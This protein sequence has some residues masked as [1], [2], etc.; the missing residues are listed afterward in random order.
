MRFYFNGTEYT[1]NNTEGGHSSAGTFTIGSNQNGGVNS[2]KGLIDEVAVWDKALSAAEITALYNSGGGLDVSSNSGNYNS[3]N[4]LEGYWKMEDGSGTSLTDS[5]SNSYTATMSNM[6]D[7]DWVA[8]GI[9]TGGSVDVA[10][11]NLDDD[12]DVT[13]AV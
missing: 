6:S 12:T 9:L 11:H 2:Y 7:A 4:N 8:S 13:V 5:S 1:T 10:M 3:A